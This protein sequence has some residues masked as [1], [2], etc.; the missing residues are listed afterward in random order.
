MDK[1]LR[2][3]IKYEKVDSRQIFTQN[4]NGVLLNIFSFS[5]NPQ[6][7]CEY[8]RIIKSQNNPRIK[9]IILD[10]ISDM[11]CLISTSNFSFSAFFSILILYKFLSW[12]MTIRM[13]P[14]I[15]ISINKSNIEHV[16][17]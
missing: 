9:P 11:V 8:C 15:N 2:L 12:S 16:L 14:I 17:K 13:S 5:D 7:V 10:K 3:Q 6:L 4:F 1:T